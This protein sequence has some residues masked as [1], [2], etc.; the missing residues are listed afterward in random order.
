MILKKL[1]SKKAMADQISAQSGQIASLSSEVA[2]L[3]SQ[4]SQAREENAKLAGENARLAEENTKLIEENA[5]LAGENA[6]ISGKNSELEGRANK[7][8]SNSDKPPSSDPI[9]KPK[10]KSRRKRSGKKPGAQ[11]GHKGH[12]IEIPDVP[13]GQAIHLPGQCESCP[14][15]DICANSRLSEPRITV[16][17]QITPVAAEHIVSTRICGHSGIEI[18]GEFPSRA[19]GKVQYG[20]NLSALSVDPDIRGMVSYSRIAAMLKDIFSISL[21]A[22]TVYTMVSK[23][24]GQ[25]EGA[26]NSIKALLSEAA[27]LGADETGQRVGGALAWMHVVCSDMPAWLYPHEKRGY[28]AILDA[29]V[30]GEFEGILSH[31]CYSPYFKLAKVVHAI[32]NAHII[33]E[34]VYMHE[35]LGQEW[36]AKLIK[37][38]LEMKDKKE[39]LLEQGKTGVSDLVAE[40]FME[41]YN[42][43]V[44]EGIN[45]NPIPPRPPGKRGRI[46]KGKTRA[47]LDR[48]H[49][50]QDDIC[51]FM[52]NFDAPFDNSAAERD[53]RVLK[54]KQKV[55]GG[56]RTEKGAK[57]F[58]TLLSCL[59]TAK[60]QGM[61]I[62]RFL[63]DA[64]EGI[65]LSF[66]R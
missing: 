6:K 42:A 14:N 15:R 22:G 65:E 45:A 2:S 66:K 56:M 3:E 34:L 36:A 31:D 59:Y 9:H 53:I 19:G 5:R 25:L 11:E 55:S 4:L 48:L 54:V 26:Y 33:R 52:T 29:G 39:S 40:A 8:S 17:I 51:R 41:E 21:S 20:P 49:D 38:L 7:D 61:G 32:C 50:R 18:T 1:A 60:K 10:P 23:A 62:F 47:L 46:A 44:Q 27:A 35:Q 30:L 58:A 24:A 64:F 63:L 16:D 13:R 37:L 12:G 43:I 28:D 57:D